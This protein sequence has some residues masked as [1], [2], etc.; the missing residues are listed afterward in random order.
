MRFADPAEL[1]LLA[2]LRPGKGQRTKPLFGGSVD[3]KS[4]QRV[5]NPSPLVPDDPGVL[6]YLPVGAGAVSS[7]LT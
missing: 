5:I 6:R 3:L 4:L 7:P 1:A 2:P